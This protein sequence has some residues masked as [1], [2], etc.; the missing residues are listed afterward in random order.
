VG[1]AAA[2]LD[3]ATG[4]GGGFAVHEGGETM[5]MSVRSWI[6]WAVAGWMALG[7]AFSAQGATL[8]V[9]NLNDSGAGSL[10]QAVADAADQDQ[11]EFDN[12]LSGTLTLTG[13][14]LALAGKSV[15]IVGPGAA[16]VEIDGN[17]SR[18]F[19][20]ANGTLAISGVTFR[21]G[22]AT[23]G[24]GGAIL[25]MGGGLNLS[26]CHF[27][28][29]AAAG[30]DGGDGGFGGAI[31]ATG[32]VVLRDFDPRKLKPTSNPSRRPAQRKLLCVLRVLGEK[33]LFGSA[34]AFL[35]RPLRLLR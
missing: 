1:L 26:N 30:M 12:S 14:T 19:E 22:L 13:G 15:A 33:R 23:G 16:A 7:C 10:R 2:F 29:N 27:F 5:S 21:N 11:I 20:A 3:P 32:A 4:R 34:F 25:V 24:H 35:L 31:F 18:I 6:G 9:M 8:T 28:D 17:G